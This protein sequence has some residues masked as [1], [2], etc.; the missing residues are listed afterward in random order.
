MC[1]ITRFLVFSR[2]FVWVEA[3]NGGRRVRTRA[4]TRHA[5][6][7]DYLEGR[8]PSL[9]FTD[10]R[11]PV[12]HRAGTSIGALLSNSTPSSHAQEYFGEAPWG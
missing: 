9:A 12:F 10:R 3:R 8:P 6:N 11:G 7:T 2:G 5:R 1:Y 4:W